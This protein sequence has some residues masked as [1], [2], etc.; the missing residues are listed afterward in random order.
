MVKCFFDKGTKTIK[1]IKESFQPM[2][3]GKLDIHLQ[4][5]E[6]LPFPN[7]IQKKKSPQKGSKPKCKRPKTIKSLEES[8]K[9]AAQ[10]WI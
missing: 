8:G 7:T 5:N 2:V 9:Q 4:K 10:H 6:V 1:W 3:L